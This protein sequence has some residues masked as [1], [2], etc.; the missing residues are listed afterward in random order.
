MLYLNS[1][2]QAPMPS[3]VRNALAEFLNEGNEMAGPKATWTRRV[4][5]A[6]QK[7]ATLLN[8]DASEIAFTKNT[9][10]GL[11]IAA[12][13]V[14][15]KAGDTVLMLTADHPNNAYAWLNLQRKGVKIRFIDLANDQIATGQTFA[16]HIDWS[17]K[18]ITL[19]HVTYHAGQRHDIESIGR[20][21]A[22]RGIY[23]VVDAMQ[24]I[25][26]LNVDVKMLGVSALAAGCH[27]GLLVPQGLGVLYV[28]GG[29]SELQPAYLGMHSLANP[30]A[31]YIANPNDMTTR[32]D[33]G[34]FEFGNYSLP[35]LHALASAVDLILNAGAANIEQHVLNLGDRLIANLDG[36]GIKLLGPRE[37]SQRSHIYVLELP[38]AEW[39]EYF[40]ENQVRVTAVRGGIRISFGVFNTEEDVDQLIGLI[41]ARMRS[42]NPSS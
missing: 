33:A 23:L 15:L 6:R 17:T 13:A 21:C 32:K 22:E 29:L 27:K 10:D 38:A 8:A 42:A 3:C 30:P 35:H 37:R 19:S 12:N 2:N 7:V 5:T 25:G 39:A 41:A 31:D 9:S 24:S 40:A 28:K 34:R 18:V 26:V 20:L 36:L 16:P 14:P 4:E 1:A 11:N